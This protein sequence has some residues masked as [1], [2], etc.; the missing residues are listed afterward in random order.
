M[1]K[2]LLALKIVQK[3]SNEK[4]HM[5]GLNRLGKGYFN[6]YRLNPLNPL[7]YVVVV[8]S[9]PITILLYGFVGL[10]EKF[11]NPFKWN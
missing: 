1:K 9:I 4:R 2:I 7:S 5:N 8:F 11:E 3:V 6:A 10:F